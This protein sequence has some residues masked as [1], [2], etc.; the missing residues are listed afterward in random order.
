M[1]MSLF[2]KVD[3]II[4]KLHVNYWSLLQ[5][6]IF[7]YVL[8]SCNYPYIYIYIPAEVFEHITFFNIYTLFLDMLIWNHTKTGVNSKILFVTEAYVKSR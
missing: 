5:Q 6:F 2:C 4:L 3:S 7:T 8:Y 1:H